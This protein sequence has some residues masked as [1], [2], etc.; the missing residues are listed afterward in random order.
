MVRDS[1]QTLTEYIFEQTAKKA[2]RRERPCAK[3]VRRRAVITQKAG[4][5]L[6]E[7]RWYRDNSPFDE[8]ML[9]KGL[10]VLKGE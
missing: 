6:C 3:A 1:T 2:K 5:Y 4:G 9:V 10:F 7:Q 8:Q